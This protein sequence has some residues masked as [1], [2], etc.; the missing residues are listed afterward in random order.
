VLV[1]VVDGSGLEHDPVRVF[2]AINHELGSFDASLAERPQLVAF[3]K[4]DLAEAQARWPD[5]RAAVLARGYQPIAVSSA[6]G[7]GLPELMA[8]TLQALA[9]APAPERARPDDLPVLRPEPVDDPPR[10]FRRSDGAFV[11]HDSRLEQLAQ[12]L[13]LTSEDAVAYLQRQLDRRGVTALLERADVGVGDSVVIGDQEF[14]WG[15]SGL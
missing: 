5:F 11:V 14:E 4:L 8:A 9:E 6:T 2:D 12:R 13:D 1:H 7:E 3:N 15:E 10:L